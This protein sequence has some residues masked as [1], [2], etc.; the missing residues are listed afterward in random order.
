MIPAVVIVGADKGG[1]GK[2]TISRTLLDYYTTHGIQSRAFDTE[3]PLGALKRFYPDKTEIVD[4]TDSDGQMKIFDTLANPVTVIDIRAGLLSPTLQLLS[5]I[6]F[7]DPAKCKVTVL[8]ILG[9]SQTSIAEVQSITSMVSSRYVAIANHIN[10][11]KFSFPAAA[12][13]IP[14]LNVRA[15][16]A[17]DASGL[18]FNAFIN[19]TDASPVLRGHVKHWLGQ[20][21]AQYDKAALNVV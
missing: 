14:M 17:V 21:F 11:T 12:L 19:N 3:T 2:T 1:V 15:C 13:D 20:V 4:V 16:E 10:D 5:D 7:L 8:H 6:G 9:N 18:P